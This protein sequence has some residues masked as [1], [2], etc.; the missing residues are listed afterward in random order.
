G[1]AT[2]ANGAGQLPNG[3]QRMGQS[4]NSGNT[5]PRLRGLAVSIFVSKSHFSPTNKNGRA[6]STYRLGTFTLFFP[7]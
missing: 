2:A 5:P 1:D 7:F 3:M 4:E 6:I